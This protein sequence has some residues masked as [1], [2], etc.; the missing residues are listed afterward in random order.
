M[1]VG[2]LTAP[3]GREQLSDVLN[4]ASHA[5][6][7][8]V[9]ISARPGSGHIDISRPTSEAKNVLRLVR[10]HGVQISALAFYANPIPADKGERAKMKEALKRA[11]DWCKAL[12]V[13]CLCAMAGMP[14]DGKTKME[15]IEKD[16]APLYREIC[17][18]AA[19]KDVNI[20]LE[21]WYATLIQHLDHWQRLFELC[22]AENFGLNYDPSYLVHQGIDYLAAVDEFKDR[23]FHTHGKD[24]EIRED[25]VRRCGRNESGWW[26]YVIPGYGVIDWGIYVARLRRA[27][28]NSVISIEHED[29]ALGREEGFVKGLHYLRQFA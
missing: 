1:K 16:A 19:R 10:E 28:I 25:V 11:V 9:E 8:C 12:N 18:Y 4:F 3:F 2:F 17:K 26:R 24:T 13:N 27:G 23:I 21:N 5:G 6:F 20:A 22:P 29:A 7:D 14:Y 15:C